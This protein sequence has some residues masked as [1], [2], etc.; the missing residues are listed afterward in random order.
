MRNG[1]LL[2]ASGAL[3][4]AACGGN[5]TPAEGN[6][7][8]PS[9][10]AAHADGGTLADALGGADIGR[11]AAAVRTAG[12]EP[13]LAGPGPYTVLA[14]TDAA[15]TAAGDLGSDKERLT[16]LL[17][18]HILP[19]T[20][21]ADDIGKAIDAREGK[22]QLATMAG[23][24]LTATREGGR[25]VLADASGTKAAVVTPDQRRSNGVLHRIDAVL[26]PA[27]E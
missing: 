10:M 25:I 23:G 19:G 8:A 16:R 26:M 2:I 14:P 12:L 27:A 18:F 24:T 4:L 7:A 22:A 13:T 17:G 1:Y 5:D 21:G 15:L 3:A 6:A 20:M 11:F 9:N